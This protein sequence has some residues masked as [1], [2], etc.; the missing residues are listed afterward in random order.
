[1]HLPRLRAGETLRLDEFA[2]TRT[3]GEVVDVAL[4]ASPVVRDGEEQ[5]LDI[6]LDA[7]VG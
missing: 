3:D 2:V 6:E 5:E 7:K 4:T 1:M